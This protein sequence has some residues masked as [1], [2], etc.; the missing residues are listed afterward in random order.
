M[1]D[2]GPPEM[3][4]TRADSQRKKSCHRNVMKIESIQ[5]FGKPQSGQ[6]PQTAI[7]PDNHRLDI[8]SP[9]GYITSCSLLGA[10]VIKRTG[11]KR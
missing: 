11:S 8:L 10:A 5:S 1:A 6:K 4:K 9:M 3:A 7:F 2:F